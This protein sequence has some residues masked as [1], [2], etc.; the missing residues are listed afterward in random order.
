MKPTAPMANLPEPFPRPEFGHIEG[1][2]AKLIGIRIT[3]IHDLDLG[4]PDKLFSRFNGILELSL[5]VVS[6]L[7]RDSYRLGLGKLLL[8]MFGE[9]VVFDVDEFTFLV[10][11]VKSM[12][13]VAVF[14]D[15]AIRCAMITEEHRSGMIALRNAGQ[16]IEDGIIVQEEVFRLTLES[17]SRLL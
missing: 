16:E 17:G 15:P 7:A 12:A 13:S 1:V 9:E 10:N 14:V 2:K 4:F 8:P 6:I 5:E 3:G 11:P